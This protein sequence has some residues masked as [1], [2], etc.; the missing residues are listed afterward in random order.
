MYE[1]P[2]TSIDSEWGGQ[3]YGVRFIGDG[4]LPP[5]HDW[6][7]ARD[8]EGNFTAFIKRSC[9]T[10]RVLEEAWAGYRQLVRRL[11]LVA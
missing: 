7:L 9:V 2:H 6:V 10:P 11:W 8:E 4:D 1:Q 3:V 5:G